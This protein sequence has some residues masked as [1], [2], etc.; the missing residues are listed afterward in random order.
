MISDGI[1]LSAIASVIERALRLDD[2]AL[3]RFARGDGEV[4][5]YK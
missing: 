1:A 2:S 3:F 4:I 5:D